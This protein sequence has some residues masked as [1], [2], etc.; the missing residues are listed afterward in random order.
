M[1][2]EL[3]LKLGEQ[4]NDPYTQLYFDK[5]LENDGIGLFSH[6]KGA[7]WHREK[8]NENI[9]KYGFSFYLAVNIHKGYVVTFMDH[10]LRLASGWVAYRR[11]G[12]L[13]ERRDA[14]VVE[15]F[16]DYEND[17]YMDCVYIEQAR[18][19][20]EE[21]CIKHVDPKIVDWTYTHGLYNW[22]AVNREKFRDI[23]RKTGFSFEGWCIWE[24]PGSEPSFTGIFSMSKDFSEI[25]N[26]GGSSFTWESVEKY[27]SPGY[28]QGFTLE[29]YF[30]MKLKD[31]FGEVPVGHVR[32]LGGKVLIRVGLDFPDIAIPLVIKEFNLYRFMNVLSIE[33]S[34]E[35][36]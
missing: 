8:S 20:D 27:D 21:F 28:P 34:E 10:K 11:H 25:K 13:F 18:E 36:G 26:L 29:A 35:W 4:E 1:N 24:Y 16:V 12:Y 7:K 33:K 15:E 32:L 19:V 14:G 31:D 2:K 9:D 6:P 22:G 30:K 17:D 23:K 3:I 5:D